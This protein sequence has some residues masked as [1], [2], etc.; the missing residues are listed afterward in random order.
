MRVAGTGTMSVMLAL[1]TK[2]R[3]PT[4][5]ALIIVGGASL[6]LV[7]AALWNPWRLTA[8]YPLAG[9]GGAIAVLT[10]AGALLAMAALLAL[11][12]SGRRALIGLVVGLIA[13]PALCVGAPVV[14]F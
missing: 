5:A 7:A 12:H 4:T 11:A 14:A 6:V 2:Y 3:L 8:L 1:A 10:L 13:V 9:T